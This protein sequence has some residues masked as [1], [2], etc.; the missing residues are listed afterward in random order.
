[1][2]AIV[3]GMRFEETWRSVTARTATIALTLLLAGCASVFDLQ[4]HRGARGL[5]P[6][7]T[8]AAFATALS[9]G[10]TTLELD[11]V[12]TRDGIVV[13][14]HDTTLNPDIT[15]DPQGQW[16]AARGPAIFDL[17]LAE[18]LAFDV[19]Q[20]RPAS[21]YAQNHPDQ[22]PADGERIPT[23][24]QL[25]ELTAQRGASKV[26]FNIETKLSP[27]QPENSPEPEA[28]VRAVLDVARR[29]GMLGRISLQSF[30]WRTLQAAQKL[31]PRVPTVYL[32]SQQ[33]GGNNVADARWTAG[34]KLADHDGSVPKMVKAAGGSTWSPNHRDVNIEFVQQAQSLGLKVVVWTVNEAA[35]IERMLALGVDGIISDRPDRVRT[36]MAARGMALPRP[37]PVR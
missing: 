4:G 27:L 12:L 2:A 22:R 1:V 7:N 14:S 26:R 25:F 36:A 21:R 16:L 28:F 31:A 20:I 32:S 15:R 30:D 18:L 35:D 17:T 33:S 13:I 11:T 34:L 3:A 10:V 5:A 24:A 29:H 23:L 6:E 8:L 37:I 19:G 9:L